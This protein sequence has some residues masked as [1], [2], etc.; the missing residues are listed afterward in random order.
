MVG[1]ICHTIYFC[2]ILHIV[3]INKEIR[4][5]ESLN[6][7]RKRKRF[8][9][10]QGRITRQTYNMTLCGM[11]LY[12]VSINLMLC[13]HYENIYLISKIGP[14]QFFI[15]YL[16][17]V[18]A[19][20][21]ISSIEEKEPWFGFIGYSLVI[22]PSGLVV[23][24]VLHDYGGFDSSI[25]I[26]TALVM[27]CTVISMTAFALTRPKLFK[28]LAGIL[29]SILIGLVIAELIVSLTDMG[30]ISS[31]WI[32]AII[33]NTYIALNLWHSQVYPSTLDNAM[34]CTLDIY[35]DI[36]NLLL[37]ILRFFGL[38]E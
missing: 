30:V 38:Y 11:L 18:L 16:I 5:V 21:I 8:G 6:K 35:L 27:L 1:R 37:E 14:A 33:F 9:R 13:I 2:W 17:C 24:S 7:R 34:D 22:L 19:G 3:Y 32:T 4:D 10:R 28:N 20:C 36:V 26:Q 12:G 23:S 31:S 25:V 29:L 15:G